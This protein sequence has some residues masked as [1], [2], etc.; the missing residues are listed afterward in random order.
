M[1]EREPR[2]ETIDKGE[3]FFLGHPG[4]EQTFSGY[5]MTMQSGSEE[6]LV[7]LL[8]IDRPR[9]VDPDWLKEVRARF[10]EYKL[11]PMT[12]TGERGI[13]CQMHIEPDSL[14]HLCQYPGG[15][16]DAISTALEPLLEDPP[17]PAF[18]L[19]WDQEA[20]LWRSQFAEPATLPK[21]IR[22]VFE[23]TGYGCL[24]AETNIGVLHVCHAS[25]SD[26]ERFANRPV[27]YQWQMVRMPTAPLIRLELTILDDPANPYRFES[28][29]NIASDDQASVLAQ[30]ANQ[31]RLYLAFYGD[32]MIHRFTKIIKHDRQQWQYL[33]ELVA[34]ATRHWNQIPAEKRDFDCAKEEFMKRFV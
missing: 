23:E 4:S 33:D 12:A 17:N 2:K 16:A 29:L 25:D 3:L 8:M 5:G 21:E 15:K 6:F 19:H 27:L 20:R 24:A 26:I 18:S 13:A 1:L 14:P 7:G 30:L 11:V 10:G 34:E 32:D 22:E 9:P 31:D 28:F